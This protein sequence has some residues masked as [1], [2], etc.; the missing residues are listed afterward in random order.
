MAHFVTKCAQSGVGTFKDLRSSL[1]IKVAKLL[2]T[3]LNNSGTWLV[4]EKVA[5]PAGS[6][7]RLSVGHIT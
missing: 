4:R 2:S 6:T 5:W 7:A 1:N 3:V